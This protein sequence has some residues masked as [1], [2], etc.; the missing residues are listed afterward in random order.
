MVNSSKHNVVCEFAHWPHGM[1]TC[2]L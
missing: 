1:K 2:H